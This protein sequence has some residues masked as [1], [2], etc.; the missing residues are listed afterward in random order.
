MRFIDLKTRYAALRVR[1]PVCRVLLTLGGLALVGW[2][3]ALW[4]LSQQ[5]WANYALWRVAG[6]PF[7]TAAE[8]RQLDWETPLL[9]AAL[10]W[11]LLLVGWVVVH[12]RRRRSR[13]PAA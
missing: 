4:A 10:P 8:W 7:M 13:R 2:T 6:P 3:M 11:G 1:P 9:L 12:W 5:R